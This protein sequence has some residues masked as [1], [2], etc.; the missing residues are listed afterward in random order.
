[1]SD[2]KAQ[3][4]LGLELP[5]KKREFSI[6]QWSLD[7][8]R[9][10]H[11]MIKKLDAHTH[12]CSGVHCHKCV[13]REVT[14]DCWAGGTAPGPKS[15]AEILQKVLDA[16]LPPLKYNVPVLNE[17][18]R[19]HVGRLIIPSK[20]QCPS[21]I[22]FETCKKICFPLTIKIFGEIGG[23]EVNCVFRKGIKHSRE[24]IID[25]LKRVLEQQEPLL[26]PHNVV[27]F[28][29]REYENWKWWL[30]CKDPNLT[31]PHHGNIL[32]YCLSED[33]NPC[34]LIFPELLTPTAPKSCSCHNYPEESVRTIIEKCIALGPK[35]EAYPIWYTDKVDKR[36]RGQKRTVVKEE[37]GLMIFDE[38]S[39][40]IVETHLYTKTPPAPKEKFEP[41]VAVRK[42][43]YKGSNR[44]KG[45]A[46]HIV[47]PQG[48]LLA[49]DTGGA[50]HYLDRII[51]ITNTRECRDMCNKVLG[52]KDMVE[53]IKAEVVRIQR[54]GTTKYG[55]R[56]VHNF[57]TYLQEEHTKCQTSQKKHG[58]L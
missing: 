45:T 51:P 11:K 47:K 57:I 48:A 46:F 37:G 8:Q 10:A 25:T 14:S 36:L 50:S 41:Y 7:R 6:V 5:E 38:G 30:E 32:I 21:T 19:E 43:T 28:A 13:L 23:G 2:N 35:F 42:D 3:A 15:D 34:K 33:T 52:Q 53:E 27:Q 54:K 12:Q 16:Q 17:E 22:G 44:T 29:E 40:S 18:E 39:I 9:Q 55:L 24:Q 58:K 49:E 1:M 26:P 56:D 4:K 31:C 20:S